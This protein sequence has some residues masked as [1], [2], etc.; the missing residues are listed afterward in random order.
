MTTTKTK[1]SRLTIPPTRNH[2]QIANWVN[3]QQLVDD[4]G[5]LVEARGARIT[6]NTDRFLAGTRLRHE[7]RGRH[8]LLLE[9]WPRDTDPWDT[10]QRLYSHESSGTYRR[11]S[12]ARAW[13]E[14]N[15]RRAR[16]ER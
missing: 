6:T 5:R 16:V 10:D 12:E 14:Q 4:H 3:A 11:H 9:I 2:R 7:G 13:I 1:S 15:L 8:G